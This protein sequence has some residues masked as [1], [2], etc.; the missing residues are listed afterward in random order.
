M[1]KI[2]IIEDDKVV[3]KSMAVQLGGAGYEV[4]SAYD[5]VIAIS[6][7]RSEKPDLILLDVSIPGGDGFKVAERILQN[8]N[9]VRIPFI[10]ITASMKPEYKERAQ[11]LGAAALL[12]KPVDSKTLFAAI[13]QALPRAQP[14]T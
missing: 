1:K 6:M 11:Q 4:A 12:E 7:V 3:Q 5:A 14:A 8:P 2:L 13:A 9:L 10:F